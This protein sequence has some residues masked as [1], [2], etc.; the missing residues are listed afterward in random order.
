MKFLLKYISEGFQKYFELSQTS[1]AFKNIIKNNNENFENNN[2]ENKNMQIEVI[3]KK[4]FLLLLLFI[5]YFLF[6]FIFF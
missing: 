1:E 2:L 5:Y 4:L 3:K 6:Y